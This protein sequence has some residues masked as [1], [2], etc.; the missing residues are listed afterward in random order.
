MQM[1]INIVIIAAISIYAAS[2]IRKTV[3]K[4]R[5]GKCMSCTVKPNESCHCQR[6]DEIMGIGDE[7]KK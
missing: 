2:V 4:V 5:A 7:E 1:I 3:K 6:T